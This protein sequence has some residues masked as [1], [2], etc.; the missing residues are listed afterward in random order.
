GI[1]HVSKMNFR[2]NPGRRRRPAVA[3]D[4]AARQ[5]AEDGKALA[6]Q[7]EGDLVGPADQ[8]IVGGPD[9]LAADMPDRYPS[10][11]GI[12]ARDFALILV[13]QTRDDVLDLDQWRGRGLGAQLVAAQ[14]DAARRQ[15]P[16]LHPKRAEVKQEIGRASSWER[17]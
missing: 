11:L 1:A 4:R 13:K 16:Q 9:L 17:V 15:G 7:P 14:R 5:V 6:L 8:S 3:R 2:A 12:G 10:P